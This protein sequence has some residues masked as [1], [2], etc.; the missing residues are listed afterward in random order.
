MPMQST[1]PKQRPYELCGR[2]LLGNFLYMS[3]VSLLII[4]PKHDDGQGSHG[5]I[6]RRVPS[7]SRLIMLWAM[8]HVMYEIL[9]M[10]I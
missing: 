7:N 4:L 9:S 6:F 3:I 10:K 1:L 5:R 2:L 8:L